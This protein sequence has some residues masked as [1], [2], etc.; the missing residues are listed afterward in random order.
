M[1]GRLEGKVAVITG[2]TSGIGQS[3]VERFI[4]EGARVV[5]C[6][7]GAEA[8]KELAASLGPNAIFVQA[9]VTKEGDIKAVIDKAVQE[10]GRLDIL[11]NNAGGF[12]NNP[13]VET[14]TAEAFRKI[15]T[16]NVESMALAMKYAL[17]HLKQQQ[18]SAIINNS[19]IAAKKAGFGN[20]IYSASKAAMDGYSRAAAQ[21][22]AKFGV[23]VNTVS[24]GAIATPIFW[25]GSPGNKQGNLDVAKQQ[26]KMKKVENNIIKNVTPL[27]VGRSGLGMDIASAVLF[28]A[29]DDGVWVTG[30]DIVVDGGLT[31]FDAPNKG[32]MADEPAI[33][34][35]PKRQPPKA[36]L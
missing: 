34:P 9:D 35:V 1:P 11:F 5:F 18:T 22:L 13:S 36:K 4:A 17:P 32:W 29:S 24:P 15:M 26:E 19:S 25:G 30:Q 10:W 28:L 21:E 7:R 23:R 20:A 14:I 3:T 6:G 8:G 2:G 33:D 12:V 16:L 31:T 27:R